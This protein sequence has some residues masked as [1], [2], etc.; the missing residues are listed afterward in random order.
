[1]RKGLLSYG[2]FMNICI[3]EMGWFGLPLDVYY[4]IYVAVD[5]EGMKT[6]NGIA[7]WHMLQDDFESLNTDEQLM[8]ASKLKVRQEF[9]I[10]DIQ[11]N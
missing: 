10:T 2:S 6:I 9:A 3:S 8:F 1:M 11:L 5:G 7:M 4:S